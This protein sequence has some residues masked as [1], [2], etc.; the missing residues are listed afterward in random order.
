[1]FFEKV[2]HC[3]PFIIPLCFIGNER[4]AVIEKK[5]KEEKYTLKQMFT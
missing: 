3:L 5:E 1:M 2:W 4:Y